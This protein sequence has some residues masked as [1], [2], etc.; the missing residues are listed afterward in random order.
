MRLLTMRAKSA[1]ITIRQDTASCPRQKLSLQY[2]SCAHLPNLYFCIIAVL[3]FILAVF[4]EMV[5]DQL[6]I[7]I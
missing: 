7:E 1:L 4:S 2:L 3:R 5:T 6:D